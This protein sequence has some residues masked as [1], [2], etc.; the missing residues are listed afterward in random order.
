M[1]RNYFDPLDE[2]GNLLAAVRLDHRRDDIGAAP[3]PA[4]RLAKHR[5]GLADSRRRTQV[6]AQLAA[7]LG[8]HAVR[9]CL[10]RASRLVLLRL[11]G[12][13]HMDIIPPATSRLHPILAVQLQVELHNVNDRLADE[14]EQTTVLVVANRVAHLRGTDSAGAGHSGHLDIGIRR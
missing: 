3:Q 12:G 8:R 4:V 7:S 11:V 13:S 9:A 1:R 2:F 6:N 10:I 5:A 14:A